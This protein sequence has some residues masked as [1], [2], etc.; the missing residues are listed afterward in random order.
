V[1][2]RDHLANERT[3]L[4]YIRTAL[5]FIAFGFVI[6]R[7]SL[8]AREISVVANIHVP[9]GEGSSEFGVAMVVFGA[10]IGAYGAYRY[11]N[12]RTAIMSNRDAPMPPWAAIVASAVVT[13]IGVVVAAAL[14]QIK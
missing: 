3:F 10:L 4:A 6:A 5:A 9:Q 7:F 8:F 12:V 1:L 2:N 11:V 14:F 13:I